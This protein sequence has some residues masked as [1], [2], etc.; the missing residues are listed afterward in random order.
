LADLF[1]VKTIGAE[2]PADYYCWLLV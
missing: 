1:L 2:S